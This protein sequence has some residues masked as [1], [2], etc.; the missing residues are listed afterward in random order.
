MHGALMAV[1]PFGVGPAIHAAERFDGAA[2][3]LAIL[4]SGRNDTFQ[5]FN[6]SLGWG[7]HE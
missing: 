4:A 7:S 3:R 6:E 5:M 2:R 1:Q